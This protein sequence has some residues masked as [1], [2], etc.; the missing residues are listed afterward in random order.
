MLTNDVVS[1]EQPGPDKICKGRSFSCLLLGQSGFNRENF[2]TACK[3]MTLLK[4]L[5]VAV[6]FLSLLHSDFFVS[7]VP[8]F[9]NKKIFTWTE[10]IFK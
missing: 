5:G 4:S 10:Q 3:L 8:S 9:I 7:L 2:V 6:L 1:F